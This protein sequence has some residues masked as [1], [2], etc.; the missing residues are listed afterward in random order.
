MAVAWGRA[1]G[2]PTAIRAMAFYKLL[3]AS[4]AL[5]VTLAAPACAARALAQSQVL[6]LESIG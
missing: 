3:D 6:P 5:P 4:G 2:G 1:G